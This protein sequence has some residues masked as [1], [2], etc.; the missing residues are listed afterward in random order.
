MSRLVA[1]SLHVAIAASGC[2]L[3]SAPERD[4]AIGA[5][6]SDLE[7]AGFVFEI[8][9]RFAAERYAVCDGLACGSIALVHGHRTVRLAPE[10]F[11]SPARLRA[12]FLE[13]WERY[14]EPRPGSLR[15]LARGTL[16]VLR[17]GHRVGIDDEFL[18]RRAFYRYRQLY[19]RLAVEHRKDLP[20][21]DSLPFP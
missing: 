15:D 18:L 21:P 19:E 10:A 5:A 16:R 6:L 20:A 12:T 4:A 1:L 3:F 9:V 14:Q 8:D 2:A 13:I 11:D 17:D 7:S